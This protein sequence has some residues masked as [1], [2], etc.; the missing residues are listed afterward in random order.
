MCIQWT[1]FLYRHLTNSKIYNNTATRGPDIWNDG[2]SLRLND[3][4]EKLTTLYSEDNLI[5]LGWFHDYPTDPIELPTSLDRMPVMLKMVFEQPS[6]NPE[7]TPEPEPDP[8]P[9]PTPAPDPTPTPEPGPDPDPTP[10]PTPDPEPTP[11]PEPD[12]APTPDPVSEPS[13]RP[14]NGGSS[15]T[16]PIG[17]VS[18]AGIMVGCGNNLFCPDRL[19]TWGELIPVFSGF[20]A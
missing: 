2:C 10:T 13:T 6:P 15:Y 18:R 17:T 19:L 20:T 8:N 3:S 5:P 7:P 11:T 9:T 16:P 12:P 14:S 4:M 1:C